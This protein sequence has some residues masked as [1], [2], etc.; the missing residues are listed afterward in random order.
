MADIQLRIDGDASGAK[1]A[2]Q[3]AGGGAADLGEEVGKSTAKWE[4]MSKAIEKATSAVIDFVKDSIQEY[5]KAERIQ[6]QLARAAGEYTDAL[7]A[8]AD[9]LS[10]ANNVEDETIKQSEMLLTQWG[11]VAAASKETEQ[12]IL[13]YAAAMGTD[14]V[15]AT[16]DLI[17]NVESGGKGLA[18]MGIQIEETGD[19]GKDLA[20]VVEAL[21][22]KFG[23]A[24]AADANSL[25]GRITGLDVAFGNFKEE[26]GG[27]F[28][29]MEKDIGIASRLT[30]VISTITEFVSQ[31]KEGLKDT[32]SIALSSFSP[33]PFVALN[34]TLG[35]T[36]DAVE[37]LGQAQKDLSQ[38]P[39]VTG[40]T[41][42]GT[43]DAAEAAKKNA[44]LAKEAQRH[45]DQMFQI[46]QKNADD[47]RKLMHDEDEFEINQERAANAEKLKEQNA[48]VKDLEAS[49][50]TASD[51]MQ[52]ADKE[53]L[54]E[55]KKTAA[56][57]QKDLEKQ[58]HEWAAAADAIGGA[59]VGALT[60]QLNKLASGGEFDAAIFIGEILAATIAVAGS[61]IGSAL[62]QPALGSAIGNLAAMGVRAG[63]SAISADGK[64][65][66]TTFHNGG[67]VGEDG[68][69]R[70]HSGAWVGAD[71]QMA[72]LQNGERVL[73]RM[74]VDAMGGR[75]SVDDAATGRGAGKNF[76][77]QIS[78]VDAKSV[79]ELFTGDGSRGIREAVRTGQGALPK[80]L[81]VN[82]R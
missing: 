2:M 11:G 42:K 44:E 57:A 39:G 10:K 80:L 75:G 40:L 20:L 78:A 23:G 18:K 51:A 22:K 43:K 30:S 79:K 76:N 8:Q 29:E 37:A 1:E 64:K 68:L 36:K 47:M 9:A 12:A 4:L 81:K 50:K 55:R 7:S 32:L 13:D 63:A 15:T 77:F 53:A 48:Y 56:K 70:Y 33:V 60:D 14:A 24:A 17:R 16:Q 26:L 19:R 28:A 58:Q 73:S 69:P 46:S 52:K 66:K 6:A 71:E 45:A 21:N 67:W 72:I 65:K 59:F 35:E 74:E 31:H 25:H 3:D 62:G 61:V 54:E 82:P 49:W 34:A 41:N 27:V 38:A 5:A